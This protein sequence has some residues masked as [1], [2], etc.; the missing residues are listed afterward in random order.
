[1][2]E[3]RTNTED[4]RAPVVVPKATEGG[5]AGRE[6]NIDWYRDR[7]TFWPTV[8]AVLATPILLPLEIWARLAGGLAG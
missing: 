1:M 2:P 4:L 8:V 6:F 7:D 5:R 3:K